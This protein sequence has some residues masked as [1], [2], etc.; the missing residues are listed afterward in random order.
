MRNGACVYVCTCVCQACYML[1]LESLWTVSCRAAVPDWPPITPHLITPSISFLSLCF[2]SCRSLSVGGFFYNMVF[3]LW[4]PV[5]SS[6]DLSTE[7]G[8][9]RKWHSILLLLVWKFTQTQI[10]KKKMMVLRKYFNPCM[11]DTQLIVLVRAE[12]SMA[13]IMLFKDRH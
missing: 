13:P 1:S 3:S 10:Q 4:M 2:L 5:N 9:R 11:V 6:R 12:L 7:L 8:V